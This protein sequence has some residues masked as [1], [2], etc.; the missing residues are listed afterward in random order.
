MLVFISTTNT[1]F[2]RRNFACNHENLT[3]RPLNKYYRR[4]A[5]HP[6]SDRKK[7]PEL[8]NIGIIQVL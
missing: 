5:T 1:P 3:V 8:A 7:A 2:S 6:F 4:T